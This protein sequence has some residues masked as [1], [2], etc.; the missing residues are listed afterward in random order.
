MRRG[1]KP[2]RRTLI[3]QGRSN[4]Y[5]VNYHSLCDLGLDEAQVQPHALHVDADLYINEAD[6]SVQIHEA[7]V[8]VQMHKADVSVQIHE[9]DV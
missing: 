3:E 8:S 7:D 5:I 9:A 6:V 2:L 4:A 1:P